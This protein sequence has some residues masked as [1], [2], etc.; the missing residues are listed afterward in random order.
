L[1]GIVQ[2]LLGRAG[3]LVSALAT[4]AAGMMGW[5]FFVLLISYFLLSESSRV[6]E[7]LLQIDIPGYGSDRRRLV[8]ELAKVWNSFFRGQLIIS[9]LVVISYYIL[10]TILGLRLTLA[11]SLMAGAACFIPWVGPFITWT[12]TAIVAFLQPENYFGLTPL[13]YTIL[14]LVACQVLNQIFDNLITPRLLG[15][16]LGVHPAGVLI[17]AIVVTNLIGFVGLVLA[18]PLLAT[19]NLLGRY[20]LRK[21]F[22]LEPWP[23]P[24]KPAEATELPWARWGRRLRAWARLVRR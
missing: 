14:V 1:L 2:P 3:S 13:W 7:D 8:R 24:E 9:L 16:T 15:Q 22:D 21:M 19:L 5:G 12:V 18:A 11:I 10:L 4:G 6:P 20:F 23:E 17:A